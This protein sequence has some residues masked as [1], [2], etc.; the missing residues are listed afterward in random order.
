MVYDE[1]LAGDE[2]VNVETRQEAQLPIE[3]CRHLVKLRDLQHLVITGL[4]LAH[5]DVGQLSAL[6]ALSYLRLSG[7]GGDVAAAVAAGL[8]GSLPQL[9]H[10]D[11]VECGLGSEELKAAA[12]QGLEINA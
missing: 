11:V 3:V 6:T 2:D 9:V 8:V 7:C 12:R 4:N 5:G 10:M 1:E